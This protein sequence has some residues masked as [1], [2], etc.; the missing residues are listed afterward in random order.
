MRFTALQG[1]DVSR[2]GW[3]SS[4]IAIFQ[5]GK[6]WRGCEPARTGVRGGS[7]LAG[8]LMP[9]GDKGVN[10][11]SFIS[12][13]LLSSVFFRQK[14]EPVPAAEARS[15]RIG[16]SGLLAGGHALGHAAVRRRGAC[17]HRRV[18]QFLQPAPGRQQE[19]RDHRSDGE[20]CGG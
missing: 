7:S 10:L 2:L 20:Y 8:E 16:G 9:G 3:L 14:R 12:A 11:G 6:F 13:G 19:N 15:A 17:C 4:Y 5:V 18:P 1:Y